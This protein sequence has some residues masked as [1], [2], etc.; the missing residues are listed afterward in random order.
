[1]VSG[2][3]PQVLGTAKLQRVTRECFPA[4]LRQLVT[5]QLLKR[6][7]WAICYGTDCGAASDAAKVLREGSEAGGQKAEAEEGGERQC[8]GAFHDASFKVLMGAQGP[9]KTSSTPV[10]R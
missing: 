1:V 3:G 9:T 8:E 6:S 10:P 7:K 4:Q 5:S 2:Q